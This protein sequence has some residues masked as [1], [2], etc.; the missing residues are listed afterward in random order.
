M[1]LGGDEGVERD[2]QVLQ[3]DQVLDL[4]LR[5]GQDEGDD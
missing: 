2:A 4:L 5:L 3:V 1:V